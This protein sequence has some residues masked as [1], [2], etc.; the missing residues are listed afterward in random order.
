MNKVMDADYNKK[1]GNITHID[2]EKLKN[3]LETSLTKE[4]RKDAELH[5]FYL[6][7]HSKDIT[8]DDK[9]T[10]KI[11]AI[12]IADHLLHKHKKDLDKIDLLEQEER[13]YIMS[14]FSFM[15]AILLELGIEP[16]DEKYILTQIFSKALC[17]FA[18]YSRVPYTPRTLQPL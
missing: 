3:F 12:E 4:G 7:L 15:L 13:L 17:S 16:I 9:K 8:P 11:K 14:R 2:A 10:L 18:Q 6:W 1:N 5:S